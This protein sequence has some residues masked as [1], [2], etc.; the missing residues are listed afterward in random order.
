VIARTF[1]DGDARNRPLLESPSP[2]FIMLFPETHEFKFLGSA[3]ITL[4]EMQTPSGR[5]TEHFIV[6]NCTLMGTSNNSTPGGETSN[7]IQGTHEI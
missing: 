2:L 7:Q 6:L 3:N 5:L 4:K 1:A